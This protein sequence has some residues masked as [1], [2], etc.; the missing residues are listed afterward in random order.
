MTEE[1]LIY[2]GKKS[3]VYQIKMNFDEYAIVHK[4]QLDKNLID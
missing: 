3:D 2:D 4:I 1:N